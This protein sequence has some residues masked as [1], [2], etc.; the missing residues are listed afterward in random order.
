MG[1]WVPGRCLKPFRNDE[2]VD[3]EILAFDRLCFSAKAVSFDC[4]YNY[5]PLGLWTINYCFPI[6]FQLILFQLA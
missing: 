6:L 4:T 5:N 2:K 1:S 3:V